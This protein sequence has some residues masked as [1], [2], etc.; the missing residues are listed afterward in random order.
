MEDILNRVEAHQH[1]LENLLK[2]IDFFSKD[3]RLLEWAGL[4]ALE[5]KEWPSAENIFILLLERREKVLDL[6]GLA[7][8]L[9]MQ[10]RFKEA[11]EC[12]LESL[13]KIERPCSLLFIVYKALG[14]IYLLKNDFSQA[15]EFYNKA[16][17]INPKCKS[18]T[19][20]RA[21]LFLKEKNYKSA[22]KYFQDYLTSNI[23]SEKAWLGIAVTRKML[24]DK[25]L[26][27]ACLK[28]C[29]DLNPQNPQAL[30]TAK[31]WE[32]EALFKFSFNP[33]LSFS[34]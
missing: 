19:F 13:N 24:G 31:K 30:K 14:E 32:T 15:E 23:K 25:E 1:S 18:L 29:L 27:W 34:A 5:N 6:I 9:R 16:S 2:S 22:E 26:A 8:S 17:T 3:E 28:K 4:L 7:K 12:Y 21:V 11:E 33:S 20:A 10:M